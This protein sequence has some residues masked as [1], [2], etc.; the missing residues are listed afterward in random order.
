MWLVL[1]AFGLCV[2]GGGDGGGGSV[3]LACFGGF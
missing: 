2:C 3:N 1:V